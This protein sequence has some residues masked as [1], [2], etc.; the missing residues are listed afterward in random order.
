MVY[1]IVG[2]MNGQAGWTVG[3]QSYDEI[4]KVVRDLA[5]KGCTKVEIKLK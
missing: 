5:S 1:I 4:A 2:Y 3:V